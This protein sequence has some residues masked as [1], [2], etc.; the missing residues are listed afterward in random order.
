MVFVIC[1]RQRLPS[2]LEV[3]KSARG[4]QDLLVSA[5]LVLGSSVCYWLGFY[6]GSV[7]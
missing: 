6:V 2:G 3:T 5:S 4:A 1:G 7:G